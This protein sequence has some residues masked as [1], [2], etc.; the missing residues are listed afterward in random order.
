MQAVILAA[1]RGRRLQPLTDH[2]PK[3]LI[4]VGH[5]RLIEHTLDALPKVITHIHIV[6][7][8]LEDHIKE[9]IG[10]TWNGIPITYTTQD[11]LNGTAGAI[12]QLAP[13]LQGSILVLNADDLYDA[14]DLNALTA[15]P[16][17]LLYKPVPEQKLSGAI[18]QD[19]TLQRLGPCHNAVCGAYVIGTEFL[20]AEPVEIPVHNHTE[21]GLPQT[22]ALLSTTFP[23][24]AVRAQQWH[25]VGTPEQLNAARAYMEE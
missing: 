17:A 20:Q 5:K 10:H 15:Y 24:T 12:H 13:H 11:P 14:E 18:I 22:L 23:I 2:I 9:A 21:L 8:Y 1:G 25:P 19:G 4:Q 6:V 3:P 16:W 7:N